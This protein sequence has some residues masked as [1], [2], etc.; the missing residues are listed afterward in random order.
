MRAAIVIAALCAAFAL[1]ALSS[2]NPG[3]P[4]IHVAGLVL[5]LAYYPALILSGLLLLYGFISLRSSKNRRG[6]ALV[7]LLSLPLPLL[8]ALRSGSQVNSH[9]SMVWPGLGVTLAD[10]LLDYHDIY[11]NSFD[12]RG[13]DEEVFVAGF[14]EYLAGMDFDTQAFPSTRHV[15]VRGDEVLGPWGRPVRF[16][17]DRDRDGYIELEGRRVN[18]SGV[19]P[20]NLDYKVAV[21]VY[22]G[23]PDNGDVRPIVRRK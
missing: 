21:A 15:R 12:Y 1:I 22:L 13:G 17:L 23:H 20:P 6:A 4:D 9:K 10:H 8:A 19:S 11:P 3:G 14:A 7:I 5:A 18:T 16:A 2:R